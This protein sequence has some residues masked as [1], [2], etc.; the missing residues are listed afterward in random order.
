M[1]PSSPEPSVRGR[2]SKRH[3]EPNFRP[4]TMSWHRIRACVF[5]VL[6]LF[7]AYTIIYLIVSAFKAPGLF[8]KETTTGEVTSPYGSTMDG[9]GDMCGSTDEVASLMT[10]FYELL[11][12]M[13]YYEPA[14][15]DRAPHTDPG[16]NHEYAKEVGFSDKAVEMMLK[17]PYLNT[18]LDVA[19]MHGA[20][21]VEFLLYGTFID[22][23]LDENLLS[24]QDPL[25]ILG[26]E[27]KGLNEDDGRY[28][29][30]DYIPLSALANHGTTMILNVETL[31]L[32]TVDQ[33]TGTAD[34]ALEDIQAKGDENNDNSLDNYPSRSATLALKDYI[35]KFRDL[36]WMPGGLYNDTWAGE[37]YARLYREHG[38]PSSFNRTAFMVSQGDWEESERLRCD[39]EEPFGEVKKYQ[40]WLDS[41]LRRIEQY[42]KDIS[43]VDAGEIIP[44]DQLDR[45][46][47]FADRAKY[48]QE[49]VD[50]I[51]VD[52]SR[53]SDLQS[54]L[55]AAKEALRHVDPRIK[56]A[57]E[58]RIAKYGW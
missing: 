28:M 14:K 33:E 40:S 17:L 55:E 37:N 41:S 32:W 54:H 12:E 26:N 19:W 6:Q 31:E 45:P 47:R 23:R 22:F 27:Q 38:W 5:F 53:L 3:V 34:P 24:S 16:I 2:F 21:H 13:G 43:D 9:C 11:A 58:E 57:R 15:I 51:N 10:E 7:G 35:K 25:Y 4:P 36:E 50:R 18:E 20:S 49:L 42:Q 48:R 56:K 44:N 52:T 46:E 8:L 1:I 39:A 29:K 30:P